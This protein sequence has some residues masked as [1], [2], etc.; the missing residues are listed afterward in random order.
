MEHAQVIGKITDVKIE[1]HDAFITFVTEESVQI[2][3]N[4]IFTMQ[5]DE[6]N[7]STQSLEIVGI[8]IEGNNLKCRAKEVGYWA[9]K[10]NRRQNLDIRKL[11]GLD[12]KI[13]TDAKVIAG[14]RES[15]CWC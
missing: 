13:V 8:E 1:E 14:I 5:V 11:I 15:S 12:V 4:V 7:K 10:L 9:R 3:N 2:G 6:V